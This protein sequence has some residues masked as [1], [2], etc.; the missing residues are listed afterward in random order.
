MLY[1]TTPFYIIQNK[2]FTFS[3][4]LKIIKFGDSTSLDY[5]E[6]DVK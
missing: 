5:I 4:Y 2:F 3:G 1:T 6:C